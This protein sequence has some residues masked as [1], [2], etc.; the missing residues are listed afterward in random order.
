VDRDDSDENRFWSDYIGS[1]PENKFG[2]TEARLEY[3]D[4]IH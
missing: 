1:N 3:I 4:S 2:E